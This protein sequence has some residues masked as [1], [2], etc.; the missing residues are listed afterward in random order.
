MGNVV[1]IGDSITCGDHVAAGSP[2]VFANGMPITIETLRTTT[3]HSC[4]PPTVLSG[5]FSKTVFVNGS[6]IALLGIPIVPHRCGKKTH[7]GVV[8][9]SSA[10]VF[11]EA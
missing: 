1:R 10:N 6:P 4:F 5:K 8:S 2:N 11:V 3:G 9:T 7:G